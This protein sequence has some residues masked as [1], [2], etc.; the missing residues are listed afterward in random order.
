MGYISEND[1]ISVKNLKR[2]KNWATKKF[3]H[4]LHFKL[5]WSWFHRLWRHFI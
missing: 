5:L 2:D 3:L 4:D 1:K